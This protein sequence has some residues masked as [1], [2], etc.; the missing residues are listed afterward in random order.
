MDEKKLEDLPI[1]DYIDM[2]VEKTLDSMLVGVRQIEK[3]LEKLE[4]NKELHSFC[5]ET[6]EPLVRRI[7]EGGALVLLQGEYRKYLCQQVPETIEL[8]RDMF[9]KMYFAVQNSVERGVFEMFYTSPFE[10]AVAD[11]D[12]N[13]IKEN[14]S[15]WLSASLAQKRIVEEIEDIVD[16]D[17]IVCPFYRLV[18]TETDES[19]INYLEIE[20]ELLVSK[21]DG[22][23]SV[24]EDIEVLW[25]S[26]SRSSRIKDSA[27]VSEED[28][29]TLEKPVI[30]LVE[31]IL[32]KYSQFARK[33]R[34]MLGIKY[35]S[36]N[37]SYIF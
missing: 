6:V 9:E 23:S 17:S 37:A 13:G 28:L 22:G 8:V 11:F 7:S 5:E 21:V 2:Y 20:T 25:G 3:V 33:A 10:S 34:F 29:M 18:S 30:D 32:I 19:F 26:F 35:P 16:K 14:F 15:S 24:R 31:N 12:E 36:D 4:E 27:E 1:D